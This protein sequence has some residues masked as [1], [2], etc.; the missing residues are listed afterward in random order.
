VRTDLRSYI[1]NALGPAYALQRELSTGG[2]SRVFVAEE[3][4]LGRRVVIKVLSP[5]RAGSIDVDRFVREIHLAAKLQHAHIVPILSAGE[6]EGMLYYTM[7]YVEGET[8]R[9]R[10]ARQGGGLSTAEATRILR[11]IADALAYAHG[12]GVIHRDI[13]PEN[14]LLSAGHVAITDFGIAK[15]ITAAAAEIDQRLTA[16]GMGIGTPG[17]MAPEQALGEAAIDSRADLYSLGC[18]AYELLAGHRPFEGRSSYGVIAA[19]VAEP[20]PPFAKCANVTPE[21]ATLVM[22][23]LEKNP[24][25][26]PESA[27][28]IVATL[29]RLTNAPLSTDSLARKWRMQRSWVTLAVLG[30]AALIAAIGWE[31]QRSRRDSFG[32]VA[33]SPAVAVL[34]FQSLS[35]DTANEYF[36]DGM[37][38]ELVATLA[39]MHVL[40]IP[41]RAA[42]FAYKGKQ[43]DP[44]QAGTALHVQA[45]LTGSVRRAGDRVRVSAQ[46]VNTSDGQPLWTEEYD[47]TLSDVFTIQ[48]DIARAI[49]GKLR[50]ALVGRDTLTLRRSTNPEANDWY[51]RGLHVRGSPS[52][53]LQRT[54]G[55]SADPREM[56]RAI[57]YFERA[58]TLDSTFALAYAAL[59]ET[60]LAL[61][62]YID[63]RVAL[64]RAREAAQRAVSLDPA[65][66]EAGLALADIRLSFDWD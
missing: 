19:H 47:R 49:A 7:P 55:K 31:T 54:A 45:I 44:E 37:T 2:L 25:Q 16:T 28:S 58:T 8:L 6:A 27:A 50:V 61:G 60:V 10:I 62:D 26:R 30:F 39:R 11:E 59:A 52:G 46:L 24:A 4:A 22:K 40:R 48:D 66:T 35:G 34:P 5:E 33:A 15:A 32:R 3:S 43:I 36:S 53:D 1:E 51:L 42:T 38:E 56:E 21:L 29:D 13:K 65:L 64:P 12:Q 41:S 23:C 57:S 20:P 18:V 17:Y 9:E 14:I 63:P